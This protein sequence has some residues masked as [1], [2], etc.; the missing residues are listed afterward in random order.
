MYYNQLYLPFHIHNT[1][2]L[3]KDQYQI[4]PR[5]TFNSLQSMKGDSPPWVLWSL[6][7][8]K[9]RTAA[10][11]YKGQRGCTRKC[12]GKAYLPVPKRP[13]RPLISSYESCPLYILLVSQ[14]DESAAGSRNVRRM[15]VTDGTSVLSPPKP[16]V[17]SSQEDANDSNNASH[18]DGAWR[19]VQRRLGVC[20][21]WGGAVACHC[22]GVSL[23]PM[24]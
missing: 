15:S 8:C 10:K 16:C 18:D 3:L 5:S 11:Y 7:D 13:S 6:T 9:V 19:G 23:E 2:T 17:D 4:I 1:L 12:K 14:E 22:V 21:T 24:C 20:K